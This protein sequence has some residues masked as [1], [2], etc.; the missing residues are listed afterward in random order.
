LRGGVAIQE[1]IEPMITGRPYPIKG[2]VS[3]AV[4]LLH[5]LPDPTRTKHAL[6]A[7]DFHVAI[8]IL[9]QDH[10]AWADVV[11]PECTYFERYDDLIAIAHKTPFI[12]LRQPVVEPMYDTRPGWWIARELGVRLGLEQY[13]PWK[14]IEEYLEQRLNSAGLTLEQMKKTGVSVQKGRPYLDDWKGRGSPFK[15]E[16]GKI[17]IYCADL[18]KAGIDPLPRYE[19]TADPPQGFFRLLYGR[20]PVHTFAR[21]QNN[22]VLTRFMRENSVWVNRRAAKALGLADGDRVMLVNQDGAKSGPI[23]VRATSRI[24]RDCVYVVHGF[25]H[26]APGLR[27]AHGRG[28]SDAA[29]QTRYALDPISGGAGLRVN[30]VKLVREG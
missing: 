20:S 10:V 7:L 9:P 28:A 29:L 6:D 1:L 17:Q 14:T 15:T 5:T 11:L 13:Y 16:N 18:A 3:Y 27:R 21:T 26:D 2:L 23:K 12:A 8:D 19:P 4:N 24:R 30:F 22:S 25:G